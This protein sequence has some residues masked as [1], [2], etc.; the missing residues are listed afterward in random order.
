MPE[1]TR[2]D[3]RL[4]ELGL[5][6]SRTNAQALT[7]ANQVL[8]NG[9]AAQKPSQIVVAADELSIRE[10][11]PYVSRGGLK[12]EKAFSVFPICVTDRICMDVGASTG[13]FTDCLLKHGAKR[14]YSIDVGHGQLDYRLRSN[15]AVISME[16]T[17]ARNLS[18]TDIEPVY[19]SCADVSFISLKLILKP[20]R[21]CL[22]TGG[23]AVVLIK[24]QFEAGKDK[25]PK[26]GV[27]K[28][29]IVRM[30]AC[31]DVMRFAQDC[32]FAVCGLDKSPIKGPR[33]NEEYLLWLRIQSSQL[34]DNS[35]VL[36]AGR[37]SG[38]L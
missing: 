12:L 16:G 27:I 2:L 23:D 15:P 11:M 30:Q 33:G 36:W 19:F 29:P 37:A 17:N 6:Q 34:E 35:L 5:A 3:V 38:F 8:I 14:V 21:S 9:Q 20:I 1:K 7:I 28:D 4:V 26:G 18:V 13:G 32:G 24:P 10:K 31:L 22:E 25:V